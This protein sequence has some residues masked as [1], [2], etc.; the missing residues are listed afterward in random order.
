M[1]AARVSSLS[2]PARVE[3]ETHR[4]QQVVELG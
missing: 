4:V 2:P 3:G 1:D